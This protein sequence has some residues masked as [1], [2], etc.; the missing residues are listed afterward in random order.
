MYDSVW[1]DCP[2][3]GAK[4]SIEFQS[5]ADQ[6][7]CADYNKDDVPLEIAKDLNEDGIERTETCPNCHSKFLLRVDTPIPE[8]V[9]M[10]LESVE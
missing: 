2:D 4:N 9:G 8:V 1:V 3:C 7:T 5:K 10:R 6:C